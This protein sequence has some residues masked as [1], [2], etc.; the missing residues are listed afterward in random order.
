MDDIRENDVLSF[1]NI[2]LRERKKNKKSLNEI[3][4]IIGVDE[5]DEENEQTE[6]DENKKKKLYVTPSYLSRLE[7][8]DKINPSFKMVCRMTTKLS[9]DFKEVLKSF[10]YENLMS[11]IDKN[12]NKIEDIIRLHSIKAP[13]DENEKNAKE[14]YLSY[15]EKERLISIIKNVFLFGVCSSEKTVGYLQEL[16]GEIE[17]FR[18]KRQGEISRE[19]NVFDKTFKVVFDRNIKNLANSKGINEEQLLDIVQDLDTKILN[20][21]GDFFIRNR[22]LDITILCR[23]DGKTVTIMSISDEFEEQ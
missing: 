20:K 13:I 3:A 16:I 6:K 1:G 22:E 10:G 23:R 17:Y 12:V 5:E 19:F 14:N 18:Y 15:E 8:G 2:L 4:E 11:N 21:H 9:L 7:S